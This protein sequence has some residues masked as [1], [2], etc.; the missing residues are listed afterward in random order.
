MR[1]TTALPAAALLA[2]AALTL[3]GCS[4]GPDPREVFDRTESVFDQLTQE[5]SA[6]DP[7]VLRT[8]EV[9]PSEP[10]ACEGEETQQTRVLRG[11]LSV[12]AEDGALTGVIDSLASTLDSDEWAV[13]D[14]AP[15]DIRTFTSEDGINVTIT[16]D[17]PVVLVAVFGPC[18]PPVDEAAGQ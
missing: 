15:S 6:V 3:S 13:D 7:A 12:R 1:R 9:V 5:L 4:F 16:D 11:T 10:L 8:V 17:S 14:L 18:L 2:A